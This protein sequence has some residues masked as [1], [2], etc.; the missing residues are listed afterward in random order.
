MI[1]QG[2]RDIAD[3]VFTA[4]F[5]DKA[6]AKNWLDFSQSFRKR[7]NEFPGIDKV[8]GLSYD[9][10]RFILKGFGNKNTALINALKEIKSVPGVYGKVEFN[11]FGENTNTEI[12][13][14]DNF[15]FT[16]QSSCITK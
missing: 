14:I 12:V 16:Q 1:R 6:K 5:F 7:W 10:A 15:R 3:A 2:G 8:S 4:G 9:A 13:K 11:Q